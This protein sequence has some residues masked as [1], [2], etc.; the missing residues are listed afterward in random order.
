MLSSSALAFQHRSMPLVLVATRL[1]MCVA[2][3][4]Q[5]HLLLP[6]YDKHSIDLKRILAVTGAIQCM[7][8]TRVCVAVVTVPLR[9]AEL[10]IY[11]C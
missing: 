6:C 9:A 3:S 11:P 2:H 4:A 10:S 7:L 5:Q 1:R 8:A